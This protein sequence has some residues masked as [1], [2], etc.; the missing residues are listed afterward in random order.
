MRATTCRIAASM[1]SSTAKV[2]RP[3]RVKSAIAP[4][5]APSSSASVKN[6]AMPMRNSHTSKIIRALA[7]AGAIPVQTRLH[8]RAVGLYRTL[9]LKII[10]LAVVFL[11]VPVIL[12]RL[13]EIGDAQQSELLKHSV[14]LQGSLITSVLQP[15]LERS[16]EHTSEL[17]S[18]VD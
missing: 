5:C 6:S 14:E 3:A 2:F 9:A 18:R 17:Q 1:T 4:M 15:Y 8:Q 11:V 10:L 13:N 12:Y 7:T 16:E